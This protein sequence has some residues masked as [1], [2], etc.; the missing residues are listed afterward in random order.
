MKRVYILITLFVLSNGILFSQVAVNTDGTA[1]DNSAMLDVKSTSKGLLPP[2]M[3]V[4]QRDAIS[5][6]ATGLTIY[7]TDGI[8]GLYYN[9]G[10]PVSPAW[11]L[12]GNNAGQWLN[13]GST[14]Y[15]NNGLVGIGETE[16]QFFFSERLSVDGYIYQTNTSNYPFLV[17]DLSSNFYGGNTGL[18]FKYNKDSKAW[19]FYDQWDHL[20]RLNADTV[21][22][23]R[24]DLVIK[25]SGSVGIGTSAPRA[26][27]E[28][29]K[30]T[31][32]YTALFGDDVTGYNVGTNVNIGDEN[33]SSVLY[34][35]QDPNHKGFIGWDY[36]STLVNQKDKKR[37]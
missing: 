27:L 6:P 26:K 18:V 15:Y 9:W 11:A 19:I 25:A 2:R 20:L 8:P 35:G 22:G 31:F 32:G 28:V 7:Q 33:Q 30:N 4:A 29:V 23:G 3:T 21:D 36:N 24:N 5:S 17:M 37:S 14:I 12:V 16:S 10:T 1:P 34:L 13:N